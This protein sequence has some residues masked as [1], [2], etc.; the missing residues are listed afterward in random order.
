MKKLLTG[1][2]VFSFALGLVAGGVLTLPER[3]SAVSCVLAPEPF[4]WLSPTDPLDLCEN[5]PLPVPQWLPTY[6]CVGYWGTSSQPCGCT[7]VG[8]SMIERGGERIP[9]IK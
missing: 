7:F 3:A 1:V 2:L 5:P 4:Y 9:P 6:L 8:C